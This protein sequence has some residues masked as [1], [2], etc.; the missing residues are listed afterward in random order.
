MGKLNI[1]LVLTILTLNPVFAEFPSVSMR[2]Y[3]PGMWHDRNT[4][5]PHQIQFHSVELSE[6][7]FHSD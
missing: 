3:W 7:R 2:I 1:I 4:S 5:T 6:K